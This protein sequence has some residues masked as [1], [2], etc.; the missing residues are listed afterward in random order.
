MPSGDRAVVPIE[1]LLQYVLDPAHP[2]GRHKCRVF[3]RALGISRDNADVLEEA[4][5]NA[6]AD[7][8]AVIGELDRHGQR[9]VIDFE[10]TT[11]VGTAMV[12]SA[13]MI[14]ANEEEPRL[15]TCHVV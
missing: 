14:R 4:L 6:A 10:M 8:E 1:K 9:Y 13:W 11:D 12:R 3:A 15:V 7:E 5:L 2:A